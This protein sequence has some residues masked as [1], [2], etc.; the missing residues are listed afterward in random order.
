MK[1]KGESFDD[2]A[3]VVTLKSPNVKPS[4]LLHSSPYYNYNA[5]MYYAG[6]VTLPLSVEGDRGYIKMDDYNAKQKTTRSYGIM[7]GG[8]RYNQEG[9]MYTENGTY[10]GYYTEI[11][12]LPPDFS[13]VDMKEAFR[14]L[15]NLSYLNLTGINEDNIIGTLASRYQNAWT[16]ARSIV[17]IKCS[18]AMK[19]WLQASAVARALPLPAAM[20]AGGAGVWIISGGGKYLTSNKLAM[21][22]LPH[23][24]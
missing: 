21:E 13:F 16:E 6:N 22:G 23:A 2:Y 3:F 7:I 5:D 11:L 20:K 17:K 14:Y 10:D 8:T 12:K 18:Q 1:A 24:A 9:D 15:N 4:I 19:D